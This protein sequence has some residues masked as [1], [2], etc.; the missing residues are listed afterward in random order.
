[1]F[2]NILQT[3]LSFMPLHATATTE[4]SLALRTLDVRIARRRIRLQCHTDCCATSW[5]LPFIRARPSLFECTMGILPMQLLRSEAI[6]AGLPWLVDEVYVLTWVVR[7]HTSDIPRAM[8]TEL[9]QNMAPNTL[10]TYKGLRTTQVESGDKVRYA[11][12][13]NKRN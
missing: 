3:G 4:A 11:F 2:R 6:S 9:Y 13:R 10:D 7:M 5:T 12:L 8:V 1:M